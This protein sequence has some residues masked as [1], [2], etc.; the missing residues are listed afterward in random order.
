MGKPE[1]EIAK[2]HEQRELALNENSNIALNGVAA[3]RSRFGRRRRRRS[4]GTETA[5][6][7]KMA[8]TRR[9]RIHVAQQIVTNKMHERH[10]TVCRV[11]CFAVHKSQ[12]C[13]GRMSTK[14]TRKKRESTSESLFFLTLQIY[15]THYTHI[16]FVVCCSFW[17]LFGWF[18]VVA[19]ASFKIHLARNVFLSIIFF[20][21]A[22]VL[23]MYVL[24]RMKIW[25][26]VKRIKFN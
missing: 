18:F 25:V 26:M 4:L 24:R 21:F 8:N 22:S 19:V 10:N 17:W 3:A 13:I 11:L 5:I 20:S 9:T 14:I 16:F 1:C 12:K 23:L 7:Q 2:R 6:A 15:C